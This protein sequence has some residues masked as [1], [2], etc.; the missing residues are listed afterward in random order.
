MRHIFCRQFTASSS[1]IRQYVHKEGILGNAVDTG[2]APP[3]ILAAT[4]FH[5]V[6][7]ASTSRSTSPLISTARRDASFSR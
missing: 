6:H 1:P 2:D 5:F 7:I 3:F 4:A